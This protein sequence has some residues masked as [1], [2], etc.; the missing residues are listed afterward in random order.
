M[1]TIVAIASGPYF[2]V[3]G[4]LVVTGTAKVRQPQA[5]ATALRAATGAGT[6][7]NVAKTLGAGEIA[8]GT[9]GA[10]IGG[11]V[12]ILVAAL[13]GAFVAVALHCLLYTSPSPR[14]S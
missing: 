6:G 5:T 2:A 9:F 8:L 1:S 13:Y 3:C 12:A 7:D 11:S 4:V 10:L 14:D